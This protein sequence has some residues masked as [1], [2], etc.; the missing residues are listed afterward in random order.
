MK[1]GQN[2]PTVWIVFQVYKQNAL[3]LIVIT[4]NGSEKSSKYIKS[5]LNSKGKKKLIEYMH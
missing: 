1:E 2:Y 4:N 3:K 5:Y